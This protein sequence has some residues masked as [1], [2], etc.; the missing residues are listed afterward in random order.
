MTLDYETR[1]DMIVTHAWETWTLNGRGLDRDERIETEKTVQD[2][3]NNTYQDDIADSTWL[4]LTLRR[5]GLS[6]MLIR[7]SIDTM[8]SEA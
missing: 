5:L 2:A 4:C 6:E 7:N 3:V 1:R 8:P